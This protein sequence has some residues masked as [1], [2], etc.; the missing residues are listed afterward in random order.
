MAD[1]PGKNHRDSNAGV[2]D[3]KQQTDAGRIELEETDLENIVGGWIRD[4]K[5]GVGASVKPIDKTLNEQA[6]TDTSLKGKLCSASI[7]LDR[8]VKK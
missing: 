8:D 2:R 4:C 7:K 5:Q 1:N 6:L 3:P